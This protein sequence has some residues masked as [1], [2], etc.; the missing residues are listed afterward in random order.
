[1]KTATETR[2]IDHYFKITLTAP[3]NERLTAYVR[4]SGIKKT[5]LMRKAVLHYLD[6]V[7]A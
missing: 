7:G 1:M 5:A 6:H 3:Q 4:E 2:A